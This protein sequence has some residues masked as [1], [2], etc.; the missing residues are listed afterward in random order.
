MLGGLIR[1]LGGLQGDLEAI[2]SEIL[3]GVRL[4]KCMLGNCYLEWAELSRV[5]FG[6]VV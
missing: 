1:R 5:I 3:F 6:R 2:R 4:I